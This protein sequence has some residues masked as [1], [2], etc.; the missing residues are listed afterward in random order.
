MVSTAVFPT[1]WL[2]VFAEAPLGGNLHLVV[3]EAD[4]LPTAVMA[5]C[6]ERMRLSETSFIQSTTTAGADYRHRIFTVLAELPFAG[7]PSV[8]AAAA[9][10]NR[11]GVDA[12]ELVQETPAGLQQLSV[13]RQRSSTE[14]KV[15]L[16]Q[17]PPERVEN[18]S[19]ETAGALL[20]ALGLAGDDAHL[21]LP[22]TVVSTGLPTAILPVREAATLQ[23]IRVDLVGLVNAMSTLR[24]AAATCYVV[25]PPVDGAWTA[26]CFTPQIASGE[27]AATGS[28][29]G[30]LTAYASWELGSE[31]IVIDQGVE[32]GCPSRLYGRIDGETVVVSGT[33]RIVGE[34]TLELP[35]AEA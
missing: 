8:G 25:A 16:R 18:V 5:K 4:A 26:R 13:S 14:V 30:P 31:S 22:A 6:A 29:A 2:E 27:D 9:V 10:A 33:A 1:T 20:R 7:H 17:N 3:H 34:G 15:N 24:S 35:I 32:M 28:A 11:L 21:D 19:A 23:K 12:A